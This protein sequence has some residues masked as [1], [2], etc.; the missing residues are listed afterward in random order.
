MVDNNF[1][2]NTHMGRGAGESQ[3]LGEGETVKAGRAGSAAEIRTAGSFMFFD[4]N[5]NDVLGKVV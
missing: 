3:R 4:N 2:G 1:P 5:N